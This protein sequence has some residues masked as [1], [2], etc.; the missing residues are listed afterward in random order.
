MN[1]AI[2]AESTNAT[3]FTLGPSNAVLYSTTGSSVDHVYT[4]AHTELSYPIE[5]PDYGDFEFVFPPERNPPRVDEQWVGHQVLPS[6]LDQDFF[7][8]EGPANM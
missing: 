2:R 1:E 5:L 8:G 4:I 3:A 6:L 7:D